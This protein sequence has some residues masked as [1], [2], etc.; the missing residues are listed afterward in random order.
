MKMKVRE[1]GWRVTKSTL[2]VIEANAL[3]GSV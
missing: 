3:Y 2:S 1:M